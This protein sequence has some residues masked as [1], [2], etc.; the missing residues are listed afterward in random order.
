MQKVMRHNLQLLLRVRLPSEQM[1]EREQNMSART[2]ELSPWLEDVSLIL[3][4]L[5]PGA[6]S[7]Q[8]FPSLLPCMNSGFNCCYLTSVVI[9]HVLFHEWP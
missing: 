9:A 6:C 2:K 5:G 1:N 7:S 4:P 3:E 8:Q